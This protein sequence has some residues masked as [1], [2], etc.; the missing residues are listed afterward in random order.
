MTR[1]FRHP[2]GVACEEHLGVVRG[3]QEEVVLIPVRQ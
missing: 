2:C 3:A 1:R